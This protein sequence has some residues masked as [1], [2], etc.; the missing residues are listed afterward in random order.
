MSRRP[1]FRDARDYEDMRRYKG[2]LVQ[3]QS[4]PVTAPTPPSVTPNAQD[5]ANK[6]KEI[7]SYLWMNSYSIHPDKQ[8]FLAISRDYVLRGDWGIN[9]YTPLVTMNNSY[10]FHLEKEFLSLTSRYHHTE[11]IDSQ[12]EEFWTSRDAKR[13]AYNMASYQLNPEYGLWKG[14]S[15]IDSPQP[16]S[17]GT[18]EWSQLAHKLDGTTFWTRELG[19]WPYI[20]NTNCWVYKTSDLYTARSGDVWLFK[21]AQ[22]VGEQDGVDYRHPSYRDDKDNFKLNFGSFKDGSTTSNMRFIANV[23]KYTRDD[24]LIKV[25]NNGLEY[26]IRHSDARFC[27]EP[28]APNVALF[29]NDGALPNAL[30]LL[31][32]IVDNRNSNYSFVGDEQRTL[33]KN[34]LEN[35]IRMI[36][37]MQLED[38][39]TG[40]KT[41]WAQAYSADKVIPIPGRSFEPL[42][43]CAE[44]SIVVALLVS[45]SRHLTAEPG[46]AAQLIRSVSNCINFHIENALFDQTYHQSEQ[47]GLTPQQFKSD[48]PVWSRYFDHWTSEQHTSFLDQIDLYRDTTDVDEK[49]QKIAEHFKM[50]VEGKSVYIKNVVQVEAHYVRY[51]AKGGKTVPIYGDMDSGTYTNLSDLS[52][53]RRKGY[54]WILKLMK[55]EIE[56]HLAWI[57]NDLLTISQPNSEVRD[58]IRSAVAA[59]RDS[60]VNSEYDYYDEKEH[61]TLA[62][63]YREWEQKHPSS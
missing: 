40:K 24:F 12:N 48:E 39:I 45:Y 20:G 47:F 59:I 16:L 49:C 7:Y 60:I 51:L 61:E 54:T 46:I 56:K 11:I 6:V 55:Y 62:K 57:A 33:C 30:L 27:Y 63:A 18:Q 32:D 3:L 5:P 52:Y 29:I 8:T 37:D 34:V 28:S 50:V 43:V 2:K 13:L 21:D 14:R 19:G 10:D 58:A 31:L 17:T 22:Q 25:F 42:G 53:E 41:G 23:I 44:S 36:L 9:W 38:V 1:K 26:F 4:V 15:P 35:G